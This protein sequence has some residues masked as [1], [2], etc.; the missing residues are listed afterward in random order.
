MEAAAENCGSRA[1]PASQGDIPNGTDTPRWSPET[2][3]LECTV[4]EGRPLI[5]R[6]PESV[7]LTV[8]SSEGRGGTS[9]AAQQASDAGRCCCQCRCCQSGRLPAFFSVLASLLCAAGIIYAL[10]FYVPIKPP[11]CPDAAGRILFTLCC[12]AVAA[13]PVLL[14]MYP[15]TGIHLQPRMKDR[16]QEGLWFVWLP[17]FGMF[18]CLLSPLIPRAFICSVADVS[19]G[20]RRGA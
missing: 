7:E 5:S 15:H 12:C 20:L 4:D 18:H 16:D 11:D 8:W 9:D 13:V 19:S 17:L 2:T 6:Q 1:T 14:G 10:Y 3:N